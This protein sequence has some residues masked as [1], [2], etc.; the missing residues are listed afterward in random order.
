VT[1]YERETF[2][3]YHNDG[4]GN[5]RHISEKT[6]ITAL[7][8]LLVGFG[9]ISG[10]FG[11]T[12]REDIVVA[13]GHVMRYPGNENR[14]QEPLYIQNRPDRKLARVM[15]AS[16]SFFSEK[17]CG[18]GVIAPDLNSD[19]KLDLVFSNVNEPAVVLQNSSEEVGNWVGL[20]LIGTHSNRD[21]IGALV[22]LETDK[23]TLVR[24]IIGGG[25]YL[26]QGPYQL[27]FGIPQ[28]ETMKRFRITWPQGNREVL[29]IAEGGKVYLAIESELE[30]L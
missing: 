19:G 12:G 14:K 23:R 24:Q 29:E 4:R 22:E 27:H 15:F 28:G 3:V 13:N 18:R 26:S 9:T 6:G 5:F 25:S 1:N 30:S 11:L 2:A 21:A 8:R 10:D 16:D 7:G 17:V 20:K